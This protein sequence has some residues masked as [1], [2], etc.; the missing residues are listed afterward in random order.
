MDAAVS[1][2]HAVIS[3]SNTNF[4]AE[5]L[6]APKPVLLLCGFKKQMVSDQV[7]VLRQVSASIYNGNIHFCMLEEDFIH[8]FKQMYQIAGLPI[9]LLFDKGREIGRMLGMADQAHLRA[10]LDRCL[11]ESDERPGEETAW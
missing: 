1:S 3:I 10:F 11:P 5:V 2:S 6:H 4:E 8:A 7:G 9:F